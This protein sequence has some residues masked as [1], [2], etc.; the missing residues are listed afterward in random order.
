MTKRITIKV[1]QMF[2]TN[3]EKVLH[4]IYLNFVLFHFMNII[5]INNFII[6]IFIFFFN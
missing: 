6:I 2:I 4:L 5:I 1:K 3:V